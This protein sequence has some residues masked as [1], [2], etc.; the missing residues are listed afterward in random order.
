MKSENVKPITAIVLGAGSRGR[1][2]Y[3]VYAEQNPDCINMIA[4]AEPDDIKRKLFQKS[5][6]IS[7]EL[8]FETWEE[9]LEQG[10]IA[11]VAFI[12][13]GDHMHYKPAMKA[14]DLGYDLLLEKPIAPTLKECQ[15]LEKKA[16]EKNCLVQIGHVLRFA[17]FW[18]KVKTIIESGRIGDVI[19]YE[20]SENVSYWHFGHSFVRGLYK[21]RETS[22]PI[23][24]AKCC[25]DLDLMTWY[26]GKPFEV[27]STGSLSF[28]RPESAPK[29]SPKRCTDGC[30][31][32]E[33]CPWYAPRFYM[34][35]EEMLR[36]GTET[37][38]RL[39]RL[40]TKILMNNRWLGKIIR[41][42]VPAAK[43]LV[44]WDRWPV[45]QMT[46]DTSPT[47]KMKAL[48]EGPFGLC[49]FKCGNDVVDHQVS[50]FE[51]DNGVT[52]VLIMHGMAEH[53]GRELRIFGTKGTLR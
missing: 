19:H 15:N 3:G 9:L 49:I 5:H 41:L 13:M 6:N 38:S 45:T 30:P 48:K 47:G 43:T 26:L 40:G 24:L 4:V 17:P 28:Y 16:I 25:H 32:A 23:I 44:N 37:H 10:K 35:G 46:S 27:K 34:T 36:I 14:M 51:F 52:G 31:H 18:K 12:T 7:D 20:H 53:E 42:F 21:N 33:T 2:A 1:E 22:N 39:I 29:D 8:A 11:D 50:T